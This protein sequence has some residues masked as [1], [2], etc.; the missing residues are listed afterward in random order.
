MHLT[1]YLNLPSIALA[2]YDLSPS[3]FKVILKKKIYTLCSAINFQLANPYSY[4][5][6]RR[7]ILAA[8]TTIGIFSAVLVADSYRSS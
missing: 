3:T 8:V 6:C 2:K 1:Q 4:D 7:I 5:E